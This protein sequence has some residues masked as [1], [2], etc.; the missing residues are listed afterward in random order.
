MFGRV[1]GPEC[2]ECGCRESVV[3]GRSGWWGRPSTRRR[4]GFCAVE[5][6]AVED[7]DEEEDAAV[8]DVVKF[9]VVRCPFCGSEDT[10]V[11]S[12]RRPVRH[13]RCLAEG[14]GLTFKS[15]EG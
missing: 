6:S 9:H 3:V 7:D 2:P 12:T 5:F 4:C 15:K 8:D 10:K 13:H 14:C 11:T 1:D